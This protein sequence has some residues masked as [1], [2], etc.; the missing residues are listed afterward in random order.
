MLTCELLGEHRGMHRQVIDG[1][2]YLWYPSEFPI[3]RGCGNKIDPT[4][5]CCGGG[6]GC[7][8]MNDG[9]SFVP[10]G[11]RCYSNDEE[12]EKV[13]TELTERGRKLL[14]RWHLGRASTRLSEL[15]ER[16]ARP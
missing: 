14:G 8:P 16:H 3:C 9:H 11:C 5:C 4:T 2:E 6:P 13:I 7:Y 10:M 1:H 15:G 12:A